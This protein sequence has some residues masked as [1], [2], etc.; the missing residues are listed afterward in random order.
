M[1]TLG[2]ADVVEHRSYIIQERLR[3]TTIEDNLQYNA[4]TSDAVKLVRKEA[5]ENKYLCFVLFHE[6]DRRL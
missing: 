5:L 3:K 4:I 6:R 2:N 1:C